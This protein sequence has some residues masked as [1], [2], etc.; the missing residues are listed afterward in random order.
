MWGSL[1]KIETMLYNDHTRKK[2]DGGYS[3]YLQSTDAFGSL[4]VIDER[5]LL[6]TPEIQPLFS[7]VNI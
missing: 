1:N 2:N 6:P 3:K 7:F 4:P 5:Y